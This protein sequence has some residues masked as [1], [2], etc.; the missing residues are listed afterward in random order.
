M[1]LLYDY[2]Y[3]INSIINQQEYSLR[4]IRYQYSNKNGKKDGVVA[5]LF[6]T[7]EGM[8][9]FCGHNHEKEDSAEKR[10]VCGSCAGERNW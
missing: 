4:K 9:G 7:L 2:K 8:S 10:L 6:R 5:K 3:K 1:R